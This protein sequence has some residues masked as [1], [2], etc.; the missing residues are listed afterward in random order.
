MYIKLE[1]I[2]D[3]D[4]FTR[5]IGKDFTQME[6]NMGLGDFINDILHNCIKGN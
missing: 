3:R 5:F 6:E 4:I 1:M 2:N